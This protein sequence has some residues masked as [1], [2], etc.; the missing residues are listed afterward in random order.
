[1][2][3]AL[4]KHNPV[5]LKAL[6]AELD[7]SKLKYGDDKIEGLDEQITALEKD[8]TL[9]ALFKSEQ[10]PPIKIGPNNRED[11]DKETFTLESSAIK[12]VLFTGYAQKDAESF[13]RMQTNQL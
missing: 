12:T 10:R 11:K 13:N 5:S 8:A 4:S 9:K 1:L 6:K 3:A 2:D 7:L